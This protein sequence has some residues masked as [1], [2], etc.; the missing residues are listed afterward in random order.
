M[1]VRD[2]LQLN[3]EGA[4]FPLVDTAVALV[5]RSV[6]FTLPTAYVEF[7]R[8][9]NGGY[10]ELNT[11]NVIWGGVPQTWSINNFFHT[12]ATSLPTKDTEEVIWN[13]RYRWPHMPVSVLPIA[14]NGG[15]DLLCLH[16]QK[17]GENPVEV[18]TH[19]PPAGPLP[20]ATSF[21]EFINLLT[22]YP[23]NPGEIVLLPHE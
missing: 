17:E 11:I 4:T 3:I 22:Y 8:F 6:G 21:E 12:L 16:L 5:E 10:P 20:V 7:L 9:S 2:Y 18:W 1:N 14:R 19:D 15:G 13:Y 23:E